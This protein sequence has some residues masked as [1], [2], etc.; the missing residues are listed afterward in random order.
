MKEKGKWTPHIIAATALVVFI[1]LGLACASIPQGPLVV[2]AYEMALMPGANT[3]NGKSAVVFD[4]AMAEKILPKRAVGTSGGGGL[5]GAAISAAG[6]AADLKSFTDA[7]TSTGWLEQEN[8]VMVKKQPALYGAFSTRYT[9]LNSAGTVRSTFDFNGVT[10]TVDYFSKANA[11]LRAKIAAACAENETDFAVT[12][13]GQIVYAETMNAAPISVPTTIAVEI[14]L[15]DKTGTLV[16]QGNIETVSYLTRPS[17][18]PMATYRLLLDDATEN[19]V[20]MLPALGGDGEKNGTKEFVQQALD[21]D[22]GDTREAGPDETVLIVKQIGMYGNR[23]P[24]NLVI[25]KGTEDERVVRLIYNQEVRMVI[26]NGDHV[27]AA[28]IEFGTKEKNDPITITA[29]GTQIYYT[30]SIKA[31]MGAGNLKDNERFT[32]KKQ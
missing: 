18:A 21:I 25:D 3:L 15:F 5:V 14:C 29:S 10:P 7:A 11:D 12:M 6:N 30:L 8:N 4:L 32:W 27:L 17:A 26:P 16:S 9:E 19:I 24:T 2:Q 23:Y 1:V 31:T 28:E 13:T 22:R 20:L